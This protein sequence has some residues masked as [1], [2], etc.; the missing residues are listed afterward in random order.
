MKLTNKNSRPE[1]EL[2]WGFNSH[3]FRGFRKSL[4]NS[5]A[6]ICLN[7]KSLVRLE[8]KTLG[9]L[10]NIQKMLEKT[11]RTL[12]LSNVSTEVQAFLELTRVDCVIPIL[13]EKNTTK[14]PNQLQ[15]G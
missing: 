3:D 10:L 12:S 5:G 7:L 2:H 11:G 15:R 13:G 14:L 6:N 8:A 4:A 1:L 9:Y